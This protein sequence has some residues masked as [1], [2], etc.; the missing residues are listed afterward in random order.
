MFVA[1]NAAAALKLASPRPIDPFAK[2]RGEYRGYSRNTILA[3]TIF[4]RF[5]QPRA[6]GLKISD[7]FTVP[8]CR[9]HY[10]ELHQVGDGQAWWEER[11]IKALEVVRDLW[12]Q[13]IYSWSL[14]LQRRSKAQCKVATS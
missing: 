7:E 2:P 4:M 6:I 5:A 13:K 8:L 11:K 9:V 14:T 12:E 3:A 10:R 1:A